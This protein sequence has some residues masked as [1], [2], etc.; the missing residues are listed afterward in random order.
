MSLYSIEN[1]LRRKIRLAYVRIRFEFCAIKVLPTKK[2]RQ[3]K[4]IKNVVA[5][6][7]YSESEKK[8][9]IYFAV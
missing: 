3:F 6:L 7:L 1:E 9:R 8:R 5:R 2:K 4:I